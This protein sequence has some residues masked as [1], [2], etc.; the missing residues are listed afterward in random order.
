MRLALAVLAA[1]VVLVPGCTFSSHEDGIAV[2]ISLTHARSDS[3]PANIRL[4]HAYVTVSEVELLPCAEGAA[5]PV[6]T[7]IGSRTILGVPAVEGLLGDTSP[8]QRLGTLA[9]PPGRYCHLRIVSAP[10]DSD[11]LGLPADPDMRGKSASVHGL[12]D[13]PNGTRAV[14]STCDSVQIAYVLLQP[15]EV[16][17]SQRD[18]DLVLS[19]DVSQIFVDAA[20]LDTIGEPACDMA[21]RAIGAIVVTTTQPM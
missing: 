18:V 14:A 7:N 13:E 8:P 16:S 12:V 1:I 11:A 19:I 10:A 20:I 5:A 21:G 6:H 15:F 17:D 4:D 9:P 2:T 3:V